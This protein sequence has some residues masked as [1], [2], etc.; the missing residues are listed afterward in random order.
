MKLTFLGVSGALTGGYNS[1][2]LIEDEKA[3][4]LFDCGEDVKHSLKAANRKPE[5]LTDVYIS[6]LHFDH[7]GGLSWLGYYSYFILKRRLTLH[8]HES[9]ISDLWSMLRPAMEKLNGRVM[10]TLDEY[11]HIEVF[12]HKYFHAGDFAFLPIGQ[13]HVVT[14]YGNMYSYGLKIYNRGNQCGA[15]KGIFISSD[16]RKLNIPRAPFDDIDYNYDAIFCDCDVMNLDAVHPN[17]NDLK[18]FD[19]DTRSKIW[20][21]HYSDIGDKMPDAIADGFAGFV[22]EGQVFEF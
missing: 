4:M 3:V 19:D 9:M 14:P 22:E 10:V 13:D 17:Y 1:N 20:L 11:F 21:Y 8:I 15:T 6:H 18:K 7:C 16:S 2:M 5:E 12:D